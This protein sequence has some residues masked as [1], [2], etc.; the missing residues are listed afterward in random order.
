[1]WAWFQFDAH[2]FPLSPIRQVVVCRKLQ[3]SQIGVPQTC[4]CSAGNQPSLLVSFKGTTS[5]VQST[6]TDFATSKSVGALRG[7]KRPGARQPARSGRGEA[8]HQAWAN[9]AAGSPW[10]IQ[11]GNRQSKPSFLDFQKQKERSN[12]KLRKLASNNCWVALPCDSGVLR[13]AD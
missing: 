12:S 8:P 9:F 6:P 5:W 4:W 10:V 7:R 11:K 2:H 1:M 3:G 13:I